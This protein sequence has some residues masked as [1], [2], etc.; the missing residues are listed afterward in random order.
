P[1]H[2]V[3]VNWLADQLAIDRKTLYRNVLSLVQLAPA[4]LIRQ[5]RLHKGADLLRAGYTVRA[6]ASLVGFTTPSHFTTVF[7][8][9]YR[10]TPTEF[11]AGQTQTPDFILSLTSTG[12]MPQM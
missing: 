9:Y 8:E 12:K 7:K 2:A 3:N 4:E 6:T 5:Y 10:Q 11:I 1:N